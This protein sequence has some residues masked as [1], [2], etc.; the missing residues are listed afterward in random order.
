MTALSRAQALADAAAVYDDPNRV[1][2]EIDAQLAVTAADIMQRRQSQPGECQP[3][4]VITQR[5]GREGR[6]RGSNE[7]PP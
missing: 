6:S 7:E 2:T 5:R 1:N 4:V 3:V